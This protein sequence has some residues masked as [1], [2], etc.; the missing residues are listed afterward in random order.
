[1]AIKDPFAKKMVLSGLAFALV[2]LVMVS[3]FTIIYLHARPTCS[4]EIISE[5]ISPTRQ[6]VATVMQRR[7]GEEAAFVT[8]INLRPADSEIR[9]GFFSGKAEQGEIFSIEQDAQKL[10]IVLT[11]NSPTQLV[12][13]CP[14]CLNA[15]KRQERWANVIVR[16]E[17]S[18]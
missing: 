13:R 2:L 18:E 14:N 9:H 15:G 10:R 6:F 1:M 4:D 17:S 5:S 8:H 11:W 12:I 3:A 7:C 16:Y